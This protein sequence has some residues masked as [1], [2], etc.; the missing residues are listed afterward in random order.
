[1]CRKY[2]QVIQGKKK[3]KISLCQYN[4]LFHIKLTHSPKFLSNDNKHMCNTL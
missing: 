2:V 3:E 1:M 4:K